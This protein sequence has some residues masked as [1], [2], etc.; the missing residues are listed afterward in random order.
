MNLP[1][2][3]IYQLHSESLTVQD[4][5]IA[6]SSSDEKSTTP[7]TVKNNQ[8]FANHMN[9]KLPSV[10]R[11]GTPPIIPPLED[12]HNR[13]SKKIC[14]LEGNIQTFSERSSVK[15]IGKVIC[16]IKV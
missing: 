13:L 6:S 12:L 5:I 9:E 15:E 1:R 10:V 8:H 7:I 4:K 2:S 3:H 16:I 11:P 14:E